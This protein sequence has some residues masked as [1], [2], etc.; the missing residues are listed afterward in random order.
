MNP[1]P[2]RPARAGS[3]QD[4]NRAIDRAIPPAMAATLIPA[5]AAPHLTHAAG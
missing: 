2:W 1:P 5:T 3:A 4:V